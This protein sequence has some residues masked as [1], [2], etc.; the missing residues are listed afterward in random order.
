LTV[1]NI[2]DERNNDLYK[3]TTVCYYTIATLSTV[4]Y[5]DVYP[6]TDL[7]KV[8]AFGLAFPHGAHAY[9][10]SSQK[11][12]VSLS[13]NFAISLLVRGQFYTQSSL[14]FFDRGECVSL[15]GS[16]EFRP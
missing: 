5:G 8:L 3:L 1:F 12:L 14:R 15:I 7:E 2:E 9:D 16:T 10:L 6:I 13:N 11:E 4:G